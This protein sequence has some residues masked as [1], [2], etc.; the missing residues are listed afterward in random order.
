MT[1]MFLDIRD[2]T[3]LSEQ[4]STS[5]NFRFLNG[6]FRRMTVHVSRHGGVVATFTGDGFSAFFPGQPADALAAAVEI[7]AT[8]RAYNEERVGKGRVPIAAGVGLHTGPL[9]LGVIG[10]YDRLEASLISDTV[11]TASRMEGLTKELRVGI[12]ASENTINAVG[13]AEGIRRVGDVRV[14]G[15][16]V[17]TRVYDCFAGDAPET[18]AL[19]QRTASDFA[20]GLD[21]WREARFADAIA[22]FSRVVGVHPTDGTA[23]RYLSRARELVG[24][25]VSADW[26]GVEIIDRK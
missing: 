5:D 22:A 13:S 2:Y 26:T 8:C 16:S 15:K 24:A 19:K 11:N 10:D 7:Q 4:L 18:A 6:F 20:E 25:E 17:P 21:A 3:R 14:K 23:Q 12:V 9:M 1:V